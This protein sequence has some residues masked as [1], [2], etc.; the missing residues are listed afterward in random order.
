VERV[1]GTLE[2]ECIQWGGLAWNVAEQQAAI[3]AWLEKYHTFRSHQ[4]LDYETPIRYLEKTKPPELLPMWSA[5]TLRGQNASILLYSYGLSRRT[6]G[7]KRG[8]VV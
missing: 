5:S 1:I 2:R 3:D 7:E 4:A 8:P 6:S